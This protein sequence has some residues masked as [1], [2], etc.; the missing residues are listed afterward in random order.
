VIPPSGNPINL[1]YASVERVIES[2]IVA[3]HLYFDQMEL[4]TQIGAFPGS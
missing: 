3:E 1:R 2:K 4:L